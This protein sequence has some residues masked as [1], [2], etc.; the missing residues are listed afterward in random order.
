MDNYTVMKEVFGHTQFR[1][2]QSEIKDNILASGD[3]LGIMPTGAGKSNC[4]KLSYRPIISA[5]TATATKEVRED[6]TCILRLNDPFVITTG[7]NRKNLSF[8]V[9]K[10]KDKF[11]ALSLLL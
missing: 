4:E 3:V 10:P 9:Q 2:G 6:I 7:F 11:R 5:F 1:H 8:A